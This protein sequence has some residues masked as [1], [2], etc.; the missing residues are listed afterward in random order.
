MHACQPPAC[1]ACQEA[2]GSWPRTVY[3][4]RACRTTHLV[5][6]HTPLPWHHRWARRAPCG[7]CRRRSLRAGTSSGSAGS[8]R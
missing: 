3:Q 7:W 5:L 1:C 4:P 2:Q 8:G 6:P